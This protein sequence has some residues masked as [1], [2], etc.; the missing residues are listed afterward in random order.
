MELMT[1]Q[2]LIEERAK[3]RLL[4]DLYDARNKQEQIIFLIGKED[5]PAVIE[6]REY[7]SEY[8]TPKTQIQITGEKTQEI[9]KRLLPKYV[10][11]VTNE[12]LQRLDEVEYLL[13][14]PHETLE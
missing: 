1:L 3:Q 6:M 4:K 11:D 7:Y 10:S 13:K 8:Q 5:F 14:N 2:Q 9:F 12:I